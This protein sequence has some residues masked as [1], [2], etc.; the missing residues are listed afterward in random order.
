MRVSRLQRGF[1]LIELMIV[2]AI[3]GI[4]AAVAVPT[5]MIYMRKSK[6]TEASLGVDKMVKNVRVFHATKGRLPQE[7][8]I[9]MPNT[10]ACA[11]PTKK[12]PVT[13][14]S[15]WIAAGW[16]ELEFHMVEPGYF[17]YEWTVSGAPP[18]EVGL[19]RAF[20]DLDC[21]SDPGEYVVRLETVALT[22]L[23]ETT[24]SI[25]DE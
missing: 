7:P 9:P 12:T 4:L 13:Q 22:N 6:F 1:T 18:T 19:A 17:Q 15:D 2:I 5:F 21:D 24:I 25:I 3:I 16:S 14:Q 23:L 20:G 11:D 10:A 8:T